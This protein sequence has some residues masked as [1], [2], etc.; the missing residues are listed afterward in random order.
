VSTIP[1]TLVFILVYTNQAHW[2][3]RRRYLPLFA[4]P[5]L[6]LILAWTNAAH[7]LIWPG[8][9]QGSVAANILVY[10]HGAG[11]WLFVSYTYTV[12][13]AIIAILIR[14]LLRSPAS[15]RLQIWALLVASTIPA[16]AGFLYAF[17]LAPVPG[18]DWSPIGATATAVLFAWS[19]FRYKLLDLAPVAREALFEQLLDGVI[20]L[21]RQHRIIDFNPAATRLLGENPGLSIGSSA[22]DLL[23]AYYDFS[24]LERRD[25]PSTVDVALGNPHPQHIELQ[26]SDF[27]DRKGRLTGWLFVLSDITKRK[28]TE[29]ELQQAYGRLEQQLAEINALHELLREQAVRDALTGLFNRRYLIE[30]LDRELARAE[31]DGEPVALVMFDI[32][33]FKQVNDRF[34]HPTGDLVLQKLG[35]L[36]IEDTRGSDIACRYG[37][38]EFVLV[39]P[40]SDLPNAIQRADGWRAQFQQ[41]RIDILGLEVNSSLSGG[42]AV[43]P[44]HGTLSPELINAADQA[45]YAAKAAGR[46]CVRSPSA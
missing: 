17:E 15:F 21:D 38:E 23:G 4:I 6:T 44:Q 25:R 9:E 10:K 7:G 32:D 34:G 41:M 18:L 35:S 2:L 37:G 19:I 14:H 28:L 11:F 8:F 40:G 36:L 29:A 26:I 43:F 20:V 16:I 13:V 39:L 46:N 5:L 42:V 12:Y 31:R 1:I 3:T 45:L 27:H 22:D 24:R 30:T 33:H